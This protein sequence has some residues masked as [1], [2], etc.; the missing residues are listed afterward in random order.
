MDQVYRKHHGWLHGWL[1]R[2]LGTS[3]DAE[4]LAQDAFVRLMGTDNVAGLREPRAFLTTLASGLV[5]N[6]WRRK[7]VER[8]YLEA[9]ASQSQAV[10]PSAEQRALIVET[11]CELDAMLG[12]LP[13]KVRDAFLLS[14]L[15]ELTHREIAARLGVSDRM[16]RKYL[17]QAMLRCALFKAGIAPA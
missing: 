17:A 2:R 14:Q 16:V 12:L 4:D 10:E 8:A 15:D 5:A 1:W 9:L 11:L 7:S 3:H 13:V 6:H